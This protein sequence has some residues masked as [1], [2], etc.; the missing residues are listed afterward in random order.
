MATEVLVLNFNRKKGKIYYVNSDGELVE[1][2]RIT[3]DKTIIP[4]SRAEK[5]KGYFYFLNKEGNIARAKMKNQPE[6]S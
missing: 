3:K 1:M 5:C 4:G 6:G 2:D